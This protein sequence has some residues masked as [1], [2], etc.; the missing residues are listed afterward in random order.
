MH[1]S[2]IEERQ[3]TRRRQPRTA[4][5]GSDAWKFRRYDQR[6][7]QKRLHS[8]HVECI[9]VDLYYSV[10]SAY[11]CTTLLLPRPARRRNARL[12]MKL[13]CIA[14]PHR[15]LPSLLKAGLGQVECWKCGSSSEARPRFYKHDAPIRILAPRQGG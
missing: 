4:S 3:S 1:W 9:N 14:R 2:T 7:N 11:T 6:R 13:V 12:P 15:A 8:R 5:Q 10:S